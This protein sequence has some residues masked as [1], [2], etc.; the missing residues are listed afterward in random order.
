MRRFPFIALEIHR[1]V[2]DSLAH[3][4]RLLHGLGD[5]HAHPL[6][7]AVAERLVRL[8]PVAAEHGLDPGKELRP[9]ERLGDVIV[10]AEIE[11]RRLLLIRV[12]GRQDDDRRRGPAAGSGW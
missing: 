5:V 1:D 3:S 4:L 2:A 8:A 11:Q 7:V 12:A 9:A 10:G 6:R